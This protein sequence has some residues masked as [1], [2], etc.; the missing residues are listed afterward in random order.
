MGRPS[1][2]ITGGIFVVSL[3]LLLFLFNGDLSALSLLYSGVTQY[4]S[5]ISQSTAYVVILGFGVI[6]MKSEN[7]SW[8]D[9]GT[10]RQNF[11]AA[12]PVLAALTAGT[13]VVAE[14]NGNL[15][16]ALTQSGPDPIALLV[17][18]CFASFVEEYVFRGYVQNGTTRRFGVT[19]GVFVSA[20]VFSL[21]HVPTD[22]SGLNLN[23]GL[24]AT[25]QF[26]AYS[27]FGRFFFGV[28]A[29]S[30]LYY[31]TGNFFLSLFTHMFYDVSV[32][33]L[34]PPDGA[35]V[36][37]SLFIVIPYLTAL[38]LYG[39]YGFPPLK[40]K[41]VVRTSESQPSTAVPHMGR[42]RQTRSSIG[43]PG[44]KDNMGVSVTGSR[45]R[46]QILSTVWRQIAR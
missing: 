17:A 24:P 34:A 27:A 3:T 11:I 44:G 31:L 37:R 22:L 25:F 36:Y 10:S 30:T 23:A 35:L 15:T 7:L 4:Q 41:S 9:I 39:R 13:V 12:L 40:V 42:L 28:I 46:V 19:M 29:F 5:Y 45:S 26:V 38:A 21:A 1:G 16:S 6:A 2:A 18:I 32:F 43:S 14:L 20:L 8:R 33:F